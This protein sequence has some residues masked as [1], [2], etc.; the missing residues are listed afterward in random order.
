KRIKRMGLKERVKIIN[1]DLFKID[2]AKYDVITV[3]LTV[4]A[5]NVLKDKFKDFLIKGGRII[6]HD[7]GIPGFKPILAEPVVEGGRRHFLYLYTVKS[8]H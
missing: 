4:P 6:S 8:V 1:G 2:L 7:Y 3:Y 5:L